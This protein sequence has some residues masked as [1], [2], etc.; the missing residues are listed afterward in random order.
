M[1][2]SRLRI[3]N[4]RCYK[5]EIA[6]D[7]DD[8]TAFVGKNDVGK[9][10]IM[11]ALD[12]FLNDSALDKN[13]A[14]K[15]GDAKDLTIICEFSRLPKQ[16]IV[17]EDVPTSFEEEHLLNESGRLE[18]HKTYSGHTASPKCTGIAAF[19]LHPTAEGASDLLQ[20][21]NT[22]LKKRAKELSADLSK[23]D[24]K[25]N[26]Q[27]RK[28][29]RDVVCK[30]AG[31]LKLK[32]TMVP[33]TDENAKK[34]WDGIKIYIP[35]FALFKSD[36]ASTDQDPEAQ[37]PLR[38]AVREAI[39]QR[40]KELDALTAHIKGEVQRI[41]DRTL[42]MIKE[43]D[44]SLAQQLNP[45]VTNK[46]WDSLFN[47]S[48]SGDNNIPINKRGSGVKRLVLLNFFRA[49]A[50]QG[51]KDRTESTVIYGIEE[52]ETSQ[53][54][55][56]QRLLVAALLDL[57]TSNQ[58]I[59][60]THTPM[61]A[62]T[63]P[64]KCLRYIHLDADR[65]RKVMVGGNDTNRLFSKTLGVLPDNSIKLFIG[66]EGRYDI[67]FLKHIAKMIRASGT[68]VLNLE[69]LEL[70]GDIIF[71]PLG[72]SSLA[73]W[74]SRLEPLNKPEF[75]LYDRDTHP[76][77]PAKYQ[78]Q[79]DEVN[80]RQGCVAIITGKRE[81]E[82][83]LHYEAINEAYEQHGMN[84]RL[85]TQFGDFDDVPD[86]VAQ[87]VYVASGNTTS[88]AA[89]DDDK[90]NKKISKVKHNLSAW[91]APMMNMQR[92]NQIDT[93]GDVLRWFQEMGR[94]GNV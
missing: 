43:M 85:T 19:A 87:A 12:V 67:L 63:L 4:F 48:I 16:A 42:E 44:P 75:H 60:T 51:V 36:R 38:M 41:A 21:K 56:N 58:V 84:I 7:F 72:G 66:V 47:V 61:L 25:V 11:D 26:A 23:V 8:I 35:F 33:L 24:Q 92:L 55:H 46:R 1:I 28:A 71:F 94:L 88:W 49:K 74:T 89:L 17:D 18:I 3:R 70:D 53:H 83:Y 68:N 34:A 90:R 14:S 32:P 93:N 13:D 54:P 15:D 10:T 69:K 20:L 81:M 30:V 40:E 5:D 59:I 76:P 65:S 91:A 52:P 79:A 27:L 73:L 29:I 37:D 80:L 6:F 39:K 64:D 50:E 57:A 77:M 82:N 9:S 62:R 78:V 22:D 86:L 2:L 31:D 45:E